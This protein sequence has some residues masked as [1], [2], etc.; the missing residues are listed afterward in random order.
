VILIISYFISMDTFVFAE[1]ITNEQIVK[2]ISVGNTHLLMLDEE[3]AIWSAGIGNYGE[4][5][6]WFMHRKVENLPL[7]T[8]VK[9]ISAG[10][11]DSLALTSDGTVFEFDG[12]YRKNI[13]E[14]LGKVVDIAAGDGMYLAL[15]EKGNVWSWGPSSAVEPNSRLASVDLTDVVNIA[16]NT[17]AAY[18]VKRDGTLW[19]WGS[20]NGTYQLAR[21]DFDPEDVNIPRKVNIPKGII[22]VFAGKGYAM[23]IDIDKNVWA[24][25]RNDF[26]QLANGTF[27]DQYIPQ[28]IE[29]IKDISQ[30]AMGDTFVLA[31]EDNGTVLSW[32]DSKY[33]ALGNG[34]TTNQPMPTIIPGLSNIKNIEA[35][36]STSMAVSQSNQSY[37]WGHNLLERSPKVLNTPTLINAT[38]L[39][40]TGEIIEPPSVLS[41]KALSSSSVRLTWNKPK[42][43]STG[44]GGYFVYQNGLKIAETKDETFII[45]GLNPKMKY[46]FIVKALDSNKNN[47]SKNSVSISKEPAKLRKYIYNASGQL[48]SILYESG[49]EI[50]YEYDKNGNLKKTSV[51]NP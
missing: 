21:E 48:K 37:I 8:N 36:V 27:I 49:K 2:E 41:L 23:A 42:V 6:G 50:L 11:L 30:V 5:S 46:N 33:G 47:F 40:K 16:A 31:L 20:D 15:T 13:L 14:N 34:T 32:G 28:K 18:A 9:K 22:K 45:N 44:S 25:G 19:A 17:Y 10:E 12:G 35:G 39:N 4:F 7:A 51:V 38:S 29:S 43:P 3:G 24:W 1:N 26:G